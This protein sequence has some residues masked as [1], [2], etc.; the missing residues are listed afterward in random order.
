MVGFDFPGT[1]TSKF[2]VIFDGGTN[3]KSKTYAAAVG[4]IRKLN[5]HIKKQNE[6][7]LRPSKSDE[8][9]V[10]AVKKWLELHKKSPQPVSSLFEK[11]ALFKRSI[12][13]K[14][15]DQKKPLDAALLPLL[16]RYCFRC[17]S[18]VRFDVFDRT[19]VEKRAGTAARYTAPDESGN[20]FMPQ[21]RVLSNDERDALVKLLKEL[22]PKPK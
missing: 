4:V 16:D 5:E 17:H 15:W 7:S 12:G 8:F 18:T 9:K 1:K 2:D 19:A 22:E 14:K 20:I 6:E 21:G 11:S 10:Q 3:H 13:P